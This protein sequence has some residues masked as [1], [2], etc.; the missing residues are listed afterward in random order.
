MKSEH[1]TA[2]YRGKYVQCV[3]AALC[4]LGASFSLM[5]SPLV[6]YSP[7]EGSVAS[8]IA[9]SVLTWA[10]VICASVLVQK[11]G[12]FASRR[13]KKDRSYSGERY[14]TARIGLLTFAA[15]FEGLAAEVLFVAGLGIWLLRAIGVIHF[16]GALRM[17]QYSLTFSGFLLHCFFNGR[18]YIYIKHKAHIKKTEDKRGAHE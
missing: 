3:L 6:N 8:G 2:N 12:S 18:N 15:N 11:T 14:R 10:L 17:L 5:L 7:A 9:L 13:A 16:E 4:I 1:V